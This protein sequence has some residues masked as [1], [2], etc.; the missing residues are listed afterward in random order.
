MIN[1][2][3]RVGPDFGEH[4]PSYPDW[5]FPTW[6]A[7]AKFGIFVHWGLYSV[8]AWAEVGDA[9]TAVEDAYRD[10]KY[11]E[12][13]GNTVR[14][15]GSSAQAYQR[16]TF[17]AGS[18]YEDLADEWKAEKFDADDCLAL[19][20]QAGAK[21]VVPTAKHHDGFCLWATETTPFNS[22]ARG[23]KR[24]LMQE[25]ADSTRAAGLKFGSYF[26][27]ALDWHV[28]DFPAIDSDADVFRLRRNDEHFA[29]YAHAQATELI[30]RFSPDILWND[31]EWPDAGKSDADFGVAALFGEYL[32]SVPGGIVND[33]WGVPSHGY[34][35]REYSDIGGLADKHW[36]SCR[37]LG[38]SFGVNQQETE[39]EVL[40]IAELVAHLVSVVSRNGNFLLNI[41]LA[42][43][44]TVPDIYRERLLGLGAWLETNGDAIY[45]TRPW[46]GTLS[47]EQLCHYAVTVSAD[48][49]YLCV[50][51]PNE[52]LPTA[53]LLVGGGSWLGTD[54]VS[55][56]T[57]VVPEALR[58]QPVAVLRIPHQGTTVDPA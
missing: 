27:G 55:A 24:D 33:R 39:A 49:S 9:P 1:F 30:H 35:T 37:G 5:D 25:F 16:E 31:I 41:G 7:D 17:G 52:Q 18:S 2:E 23:P 40:S 42:A 34:L 44:G 36:E 28:S 21:Y 19:F 8:P 53:P 13:Y 20:R 26:S 57:L 32:K 12:W 58:S 15:E 38:R 56:Q 47:D 3:D 46:S 22:A 6:L 45:H 54:T 29:R 43:D 10:H 50:L 48:A 51:T 14:V 11:A 4:N